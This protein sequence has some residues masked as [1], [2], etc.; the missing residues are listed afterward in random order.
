M[1]GGDHPRA[2]EL[3]RH[4]RR[5][6]AKALELE[7]Q[8]RVFRRIQAVLFVTEG[9]SVSEAARRVRADRSAVHRWIDW[10]LRRRDPSD[11]ADDPRSGRPARAQRIDESAIVDALE[12]DPREQG[13]LATTWTVPLLATYL[14]R[15]TGHTV[16]QRTLRRRLHESHY[17]WKRPRYVYTGQEPNLPQKKGRFFDG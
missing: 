1:S 16:S 12:R 4:D 11:L 17:R 3:T 8:A 14:S 6:L 7:T 15:V 10:Y 5:R 13:F 2:S 9:V